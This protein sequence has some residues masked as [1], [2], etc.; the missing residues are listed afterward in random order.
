MP[1]LT[2]FISKKT[3]LA[4]LALVALTLTVPL[5]MSVSTARAIDPLA[6]S[7]CVSGDWCGWD[8]SGYSGQFY[9]FN[10]GQYGYNANTWYDITLVQYPGPIQSVANRRDHNVWFSYVDPPYSNG[11]PPAGTK[12]CMIPGGGRGDLTQWHY[13]NGTNENENVWALDMLSSGTSC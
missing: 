9:P 6:S 2:R 7:Q 10:T 3:A 5:F 8:G 12:D 4:P 13:P 11:V 1:R